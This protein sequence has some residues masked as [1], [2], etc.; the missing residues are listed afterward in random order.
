MGEDADDPEAYHHDKETRRAM[1]HD[2]LV[3][4]SQARGAH[5]RI[6]KYG[7]SQDERSCRPPPFQAQ[8][9]RVPNKPPCPRSND[10]VQSHALRSIFE[11]HE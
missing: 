7:C 8:G 11:V 9:G 3:V 10:S 2:R 1:H 5:Q 4:E 6:G